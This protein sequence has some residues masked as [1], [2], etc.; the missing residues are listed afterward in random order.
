[1]RQQRIVYIG[2]AGWLGVS[3]LT[4]AHAA[5]LP[6]HYFK[7]LEAGLGSL[8]PHNLKSNPGAMLAAA[9]FYAKPHAADL[10]IGELTFPVTARP[11]PADAPLDWRRG[12]VAFALGAGVGPEKVTGPAGP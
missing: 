3:G 8:D 11:P 6:G 7:L 1:V 5:E 4:A 10:P 2:R 12:E 9:V